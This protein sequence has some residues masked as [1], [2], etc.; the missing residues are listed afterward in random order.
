M[1]CRTADA[2]LASTLHPSDRDVGQRCCERSER[3]PSGTDR[4]DRE[5]DPVAAGRGRGARSR[6]DGDPHPA[7]TGD[8][9][10][11]THPP[12]GPPA[13]CTPADGPRGA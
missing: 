3:S 4:S 5:P 9:G 12:G 6:R 13:R 11:V 1:P 8:T 7:P 10:P 2:T